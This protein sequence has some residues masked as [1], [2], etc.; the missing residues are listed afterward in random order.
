MKLALTIIGAA[1]I[2]STSSVGI[3][4][5]QA[6]TPASN[7]EPAARAYSLFDLV[8]SDLVVIKV[9]LD[10]VPSD[11]IEANLAE[12]R[13]PEGPPP[14]PPDV[15]IDAICHTLA[16]ASPGARHSHR[17]LRAVNLAGKQVP[18]ARG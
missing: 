10:P 15:S 13:Q 1:L 3:A 8:F 5:V 17:L 14:P 4:S 18:A 2:A 7:V 9:A 16:S 6:V 12:L 11:V